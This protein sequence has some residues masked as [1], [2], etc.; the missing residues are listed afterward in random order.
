MEGSAGVQ[1]FT[2]SIRQIIEMWFS[3]AYNIHKATNNIKHNKI[4]L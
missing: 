4:V 2:L 1:I 3:N